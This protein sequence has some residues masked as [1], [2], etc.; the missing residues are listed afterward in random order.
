[1]K[2]TVGFRM[3]VEGKN[4]SGSKPQNRKAGVHRE[5]SS[6]SNVSVRMMETTKILLQ[7]VPPSRLPE[8]YMM[9]HQCLLNTQAKTTHVLSA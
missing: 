8:T 4:S 9:S 6:F 3:V 2:D 7:L 1:M 5:H